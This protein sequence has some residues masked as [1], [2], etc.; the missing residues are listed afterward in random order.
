M[1]GGGRRCY[2]LAVRLL[3]RRFTLELPLAV[4]AL[5]PEKSIIVE[6]EGKWNRDFAP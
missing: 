1:L 6:G 3:R 2:V 4:W 5:A